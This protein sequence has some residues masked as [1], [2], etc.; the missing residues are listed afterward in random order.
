MKLKLTVD[1][2]CAIGPTL[3]ILT[4]SVRSADVLSLPRFV[5]FF[6]L[7]GSA[8]ARALDNA[9]RPN[10][11]LCTVEVSRVPELSRIR[12]RPRPLKELDGRARAARL[13]LEQEIYRPHLIRLG[14]RVTAE[15]LSRIDAERRIP[16]ARGVPS[17]AA[18]FR[19]LVDE[20]LAWRSSVRP[21]SPPRP[22]RGEPFFIDTSDFARRARR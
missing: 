21:K 11:N 7:T 5:S 6:R 15:Q 17:M 20:A 4:R 9:E 22:P 14:L 19:E 2:H 10:Q 16:D 12:R 8:A 1:E 13:A 18:L 3:I